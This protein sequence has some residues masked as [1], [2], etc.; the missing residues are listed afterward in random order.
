MET[1]PSARMARVASY[2][3]APATPNC[4]LGCEQQG[5]GRQGPGGGPSRLV[6]QCVVAELEDVEYAGGD[7]LG[8]RVVT[9]PV[10]VDCGQFEIGSSVRSYDDHFAVEDDLA[11]QGETSQ[12]PELFGPFASGPRPP[13]GPGK[14]SPVRGEGTTYPL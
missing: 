6:A 3:A 14:A 12:L 8:V 11:E 5:P 1:V 2:I 10:D 4:G 9:R 7:R 13:A